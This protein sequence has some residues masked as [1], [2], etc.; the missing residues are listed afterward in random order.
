[1]SFKSRDKITIFSKPATETS[2]DLW[3]VEINGKNGYAPKKFIQEDRV[4]VSSSKL[5]TVQNVAVASE[6]P[7]LAT[8]TENINESLPD[9]QSV[10]VSENASEATNTNVNGVQDELSAERS[11]RSI[12][13]PSLAS[14]TV[15]VNE[16]LDAPN[17]SDEVK[18]EDLNKYDS[19]N[20]D[21]NA[22]ANDEDD[23]EEG[24]DEDEDEY[25]D[26]ENA[27]DSELSEEE[28]EEENRIPVNEEPFIKKT[29]YVTTDSKVL[30]SGP[31]GNDDAQPTLEIMAPTQ[32]EI[33][34]LKQ[35]QQLKNST[36][37]TKD[38]S[39]P[40]TAKSSVD[41]ESIAAP[42]ISTTAASKSEPAASATQFTTTTVPIDG[43]QNPLH[44]PTD[45]TT[46]L[47]EAT[48]KKQIIY[49]STAA[50]ATIASIPTNV[51]SSTSA[52]IDVTIPKTNIPTSNDILKSEEPLNTDA[53]EIL[54]EQIPPFKPLPPSTPSVDNQGSEINDSVTDVPNIAVVDQ[55]INL[56]YG[57]DAV[58]SV[59]EETVK[60]I[61]SSSDNNTTTNDEAITVSD[62]E[63]NQI[64]NEGESVPVATQP[65]EI[66]DEATNISEV[67]N[68]SLPTEETIGN[69]AE[70]PQKDVKLIVD[71][72]DTV[73]IGNDS[74]E[75]NSNSDGIVHAENEI[76][77][78]LEIVKSEEIVPTIDYL[79][80][81]INEGVGII[82]PIIQSSNVEEQQQETQ[83]ENNLESEQTVNAESKEGI[84]STLIN[85]VRNL[86]GGSSSVESLVEEESSNENFDKALNDI[87]FSQAVPTSNENDNS[88]GMCR[89]VNKLFIC[90]K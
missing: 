40:S 7:A 77:S 39:T 42:S 5:V 47:P 26:A 69:L 74:N 68:D 57:V 30:K 63:K 56:S 2:D 51:V 36:P 24:D 87:L 8:K 88:Q 71:G 55:K 84:F 35:Q 32:S 11:K 86:F 33:E 43:P 52:K 45:T 6:T 14:E 19:K 81:K 20:F 17:A 83:T 29:A 80:Q 10:E 82:E 73:S 9:V 1:M 18:I 12:D 16:N 31:I 21:E 23:E 22:E 58:P 37:E 64:L 50:P 15:K 75:S 48:T 79:T 49:T 44:I 72:L 41:T 62:E 85:S 4:L 89:L 28:G 13:E 38:S 61:T 59:I 78:Q 70:P 65:A 54:N 60:P 34:Q 67:N 27:V 66:V 46:P 90:K 53:A 76:V 25:D 3:Y